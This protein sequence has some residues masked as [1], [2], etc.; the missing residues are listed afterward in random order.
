M[1]S[2]PFL[3][4]DLL[5]RTPPEVQAY[6]RALE[7][8]VAA[9]ETT[10]HPV[11]EQLQQDSRTSSRPPSSDPPPA[12][13]QR[14]RREPTGRR[15][16]GQPGPEGHARGVVPVQEVDVVIPVK[17][18]RGRHCQPPL[19]GEEAQPQRHQVPEISPVEPVATEDEL[20]QLVCPAC[21]AVTRAEVPPG[22][23]T[24]G[25]SPRVQAITAQCTGA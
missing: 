16:G 4:S 5:E 18:E 19:P 23:P 2:E 15:P 12:L 3:S 9:L 10:L 13:T 22:V 1:N 24:G 7:A 11:R 6:I 8:R 14:P 25:F 20:H 21:G 17:P